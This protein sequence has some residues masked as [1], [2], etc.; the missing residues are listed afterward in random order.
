MPWKFEKIKNFLLTSQKKY[1]KF[2]KNK[3]NSNKD[4]M[5]F[6]VQ[7]SRCLYT[8]VSTDREKA[9]IL[10]QSLPPGLAAKELK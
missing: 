4:N 8:L 10:K 6:K 1:A 7:C 3:I 5:K 2:I 9:E